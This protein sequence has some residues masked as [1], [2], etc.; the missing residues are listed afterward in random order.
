MGSAN[1]LGISGYRH[2]VLGVTRCCSYQM[3]YGPMRVRCRIEETELDGDYSIV[4]GIEA[5]CLRCDHI[6]ESYGTDTAS[7]KRCLAVMR[8]ECP[9]GESNFYVETK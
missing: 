7:R 4:E 2:R 9:R 6:T 1:D 8:E 3:G 5:R